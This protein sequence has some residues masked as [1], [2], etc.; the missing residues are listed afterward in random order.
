V[1]TPILPILTSI[2][3]ILSQPARDTA[4]AAPCLSADSARGATRYT[5]VTAAVRPSG[6]LLVWRDAPDSVRAFFT[7]NDRGR[8]PR[9]MSRYALGS[10]G[11]PVA[12]Q[13]AGV[14]YLKVPVTESYTIDGASGG[15]RA[16]WRSAAEHDSASVPNG[17]APYYVT[18][19][20]PAFEDGL[21]AGAALRAGAA[22]LALLPTGR[23]YAERVRDT[24]VTDST[25]RTQRVTLVAVRGLGFTPMPVWL[26]SAG[27]LFATGG[28][29]MMTVRAGYE[30]IV[31][32][33]DGIQRAWSAAHQRE[34][35]R[36]LAHRPDGGAL[37]VRNARLFDPTT[38]A[39]RNAIT[40]VVREN[41]ITQVAPDA[42]VPASALP[43]GATVIDAGGRTL[44]PGLWD[45]HVHTDAG[46]GIFHLAAGVTTVRD[47]GNDW[48]LLETGRRWRS[49]DALGPR[50]LMSGFI[51]GPGPFTGPTG[52][53]A[54][55][56]EQALADVDRYAD[57]GYV[58]I[59]VYSSL[60]TAFVAPIA[61]RAH[62]RGLR[63][64]GH[65]PNGMTAERFVRAGADEVQH[66]N[67]LML[68]FIADS[69]GDT[70]TPSR[71]T[72]PA[73]LG[74]LLDV[75][76]DSVRRFIA[77]LREH[78]TVSDPTLNAFEEMF[79]QRPGIVPAAWA[80]VLDRMPPQ[81]QR[82]L[83]AGN[84]GLPI[85]DS[86]PGMDARYRESFTRMMDLVR[87]LHDAGVTIVAGTDAIPG[88]SLHRELELYVQ[89]G[90]PAPEVLRIATLGAARVMHRDTDLGTVAAGKLADFIVLDGDP[91]ARISDIRKTWLVVRDGIVFRPDE[92][93]AELG[94]R[95]GSRAAGR[96]R[97][98]TR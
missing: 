40:V 42:S 14:D 98:S 81:V 63:L 93:Y 88:W 86:P 61:A 97:L 55:T 25:G 95:T 18:M 19:N 39:S 23:A 94:V 62:A 43:S 91:T 85:P 75:K 96:A 69:A 48:T 26:D 21:L 71:F 15:R 82:S 92:L 70:R 3:T 58:Q 10:T 54:S 84:G 52:V 12:V 60:D 32:A 41:R 74:A 30:G 34:V 6:C 65:V 45:M 80:P 11:A 53:V 35:A 66:A 28:A 2:L 31:G 27:A 4:A 59:K 78:G 87:A 64:S 22:G 89:A 1:A 37:V 79:T 5:V 46:D 76:S 47:M 9:V 20:G 56:L 68:N 16:R 17:S 44:L 29:W 67:F 50:L 90:I 36:R 77:L 83:R 7:F 51:D 24:V 33:L 8:G 72:V 38:L 57:S 49:G 13:I 73:R